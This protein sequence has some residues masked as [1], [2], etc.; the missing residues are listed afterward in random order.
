MLQIFQV[1]V[2]LTFIFLLSFDNVI[3]F[4]QR[5]GPLVQLFDVAVDRP[6]D[7]EITQNVTLLVLAQLLGNAFLLALL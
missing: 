5:Q 6:L 3:E 7:V 2:M 1:F 4:F